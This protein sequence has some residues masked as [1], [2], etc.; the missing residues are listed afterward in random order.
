[1]KKKNMDRIKKTETHENSFDWWRR[2]TQNKGV[3]L[4]CCVAKAFTHPLRWWYKS[5]DVVLEIIMTSLQEMD[6]QL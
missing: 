4:L 2:A 3:T 1:M 6:G 5:S